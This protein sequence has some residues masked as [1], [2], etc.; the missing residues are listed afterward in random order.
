[1]LSFSSWSYHST[2]WRYRRKAAQLITYRRPQRYR[3]ILDTAPVARRDT[4]IMQEWGRT[5]SLAVE[6]NK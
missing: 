1:M 4:N 3:V 6:K 5:K 2:P